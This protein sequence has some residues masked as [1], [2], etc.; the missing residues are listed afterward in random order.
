MASALSRL[1]VSIDPSRTLDTVDARVDQAVNTFRMSAGAITRWD[2]FRNCLI[3]F[4]AHVE[5]Q[6]LCLRGYPEVS[7]DFHWGR[8]VRLL[9]QEYGA[10]GD[11]TAYEMSRTGNEGGLYGVL[12]AVARRI[13]T[14]YAKNEIVARISAFWDGLSPEEQLS[15]STLYL[16]QY[17]HLLPSELTEGSAARLRASFPK[18]LEEHPY[19]MRRLRRIGR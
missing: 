6:V 11:K 18:V 8:C 10:N 14:Q 17:G 13:A 16:A 4:L 19:L 7:V 9:L 2:D 12:K 5:T 1:L 3:R 15:T